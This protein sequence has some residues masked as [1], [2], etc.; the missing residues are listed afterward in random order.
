[1]TVIPSVREYDLIVWGASGFT[2]RLVVE[3]LLA[4]YPPGPDLRW[5]VAGRDAAKLKRVVRK[6]ATDDLQLPVLTG[7]GLDAVSMQSLARSTRVILSTAGPYA[8]FGT[9]L[10]AACA[11]NGTHYC[12]LSGEPQ[13]MRR[14]IDQYHGIAQQSG[15]RIVHSCGF[16]SI[17][18]DFGVWFLQQQAQETRGR[19]CEEIRLLVKATKGGASGG[20]IAS[21]LN[22]MAEARADRN[23][24][25]ILVDPYSLNPE[26]ERQGPDARD[27]T[28]IAFDDISGTWT[29]PFVMATINTKIVRRTNALLG[30]PYGRDFRYSEAVM[31]GSGPA[32]W[33]KAAGI[34]A[35]L[36]AFML[37]SG[38]RVA[39]S[40]IVER[41][42]PKPGEGPNREQRENGFFNLQLTGSFAGGELLRARVTGD[43]DPG[44]GSTSKMLSESAVCLVQD[45]LPI[46]GGFWTPVSAM[47][48]AL[49]QRLTTR[50][51]LSF[52]ILE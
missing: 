13:W 33:C 12:D 22:V 51:G 27:Q 20:T 1:M 30:Y 23:I 37:M 49:M 10:V 9:P 24:A 5:A 3:Y 4:H 39:R 36:G 34:T 45:D 16:D 18:S 41:L 50:A 35:G 44:Y 2:G 15:A 21:S 48:D 11:D 25:R 8:R 43:R 42:L 14:M 6:L 38:N 17:P 32:G 46:R 7:D 28:G 31:A 47:R 52:S 26:G 40:Q 29:A 19:S